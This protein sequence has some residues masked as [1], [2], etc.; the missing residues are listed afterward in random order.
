MHAS[1]DG[2]ARG[3]MK[4]KLPI[5]GALIAAPRE[6]E[7]K[8]RDVLIELGVGDAFDDSAVHELRFEIGRIYGAWP[9]EQE[10]A[11][12]SPVA[13]ALRSTARSL[14]D[15]A[16]VLSG[17]ETGLR[18]H[19]EIEAT[20]NTATILALD[21]TVGSLDRAVDCNFGV[22]RMSPHEGDHCPG[23][24]GLRGCRWRCDHG[25]RS[26]SLGDDGVRQSQLLSH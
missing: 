9:S 11:E 25:D 13:K 15:A 4:R 8:L 17:L 2:G 26:P 3:S 7:A 23:D 19:V 6:N 20:R 16:A 12:V 10:A 22:H 1:Y 14:L 18:T 5:G 24:T 21:P